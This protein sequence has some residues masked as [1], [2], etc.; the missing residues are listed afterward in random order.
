MV[1]TYLLF[2]RGVVIDRNE[3]DKIFNEDEK[4]QFEDV[5]FLSTSDIE[6]KIGLLKKVNG[7]VRTKLGSL[8]EVFNYFCDSELAQK[9][10]ILGY[11]VEQYKFQRSD[12][13]DCKCK[14]E[15]EYKTIHIDDIHNKL[16]SRETLNIHPEICN[17]INHEEIDE[18]IK[19]LLKKKNISCEKGS[20]NYYFLLDDCPCCS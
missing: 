2:I 17:F 1:Y 11:K 10:F 5:D 9:K 19:S 15:G 3:V 6:L 14:I 4:K 18:K 8:L 12:L 20:N 16:A 13:D 7:N